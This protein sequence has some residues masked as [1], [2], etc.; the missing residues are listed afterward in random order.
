MFSS[1][2]TSLDTSS[3][4]SS[5][6]LT[7]AASPLIAEALVAML[8]LAEF[9]EAFKEVIF[10]EVE[11][12]AASLTPATSKRLLA[13]CD[14]ELPLAVICVCKLVSEDEVEPAVEDAQVEPV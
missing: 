11:I 2:V 6:T 12:S 1:S 5:V 3:I 9:I 4:S 13:F 8:P 14:I 7:L 10:T